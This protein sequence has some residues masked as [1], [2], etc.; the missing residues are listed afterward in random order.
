MR[1]DMAG[2]ASQPG[3]AGAIQAR[4]GAVRIEAAGD[5][6][7]EDRGQAGV[8]ALVAQEAGHQIGP[9]DRDDLAPQAVA[10]PGGEGAA[11]GEVVVMGR[12]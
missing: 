2:A 3:R 6:V 7:V 11:G 8:G 12:G 5:D 4:G 9:G 10:L 1:A